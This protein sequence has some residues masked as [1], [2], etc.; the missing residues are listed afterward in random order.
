MSSLQRLLL[1]DFPRSQERLF[2]SGVSATARYL[3]S[4]EAAP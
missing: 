1:A 3:A 2:G 4:P